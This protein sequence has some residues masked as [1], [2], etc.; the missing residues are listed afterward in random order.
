MKKLLISCMVMLITLS[1]FAQKAEEKKEEPKKAEGPMMA[2]KEDSFDFGGIE[3][4]DVVEHTFEFENKG[5]EPLIISNVAV[6][7][8]CTVPS[9]PREPIPAG[10][11]S[12]IVV[13]FNSTGKS[14]AQHKVVRIT[15]NMTIPIAEVSITT[16]VL[17]KKK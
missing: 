6:T 1:A 15:T 11:K 16:N 12:K 9:W 3:Q 14:G 4:G 5:T 17:P 13:K 10:E 2:F 8:G 7:C